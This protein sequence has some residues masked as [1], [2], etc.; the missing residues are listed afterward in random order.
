MHKHFKKKITYENFYLDAN[1]KQKLFSILDFYAK[2]SIL[3]S[4]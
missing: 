3:K 4:S 2:T 1:A